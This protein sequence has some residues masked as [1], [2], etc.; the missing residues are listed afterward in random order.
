MSTGFASDLLRYGTYPTALLISVVGALVT[1]ERGADPGLV[2]TTISLGWIPLF[3]AIERWCPE[4]T[5]WRPPRSEVGA[6]VL[7]MLVS[8]PI[9]MAI[10]RATLYGAVVAASG[11]ITERFGLELWPITWPLW[12]QAG[13]AILVA[14]LANYAIHRGMHESRLWPLHAVHHCS[15]RMYFLLS[16]RKHPLQSFV[17]YGG[18]FAVL[19][20]LGVGEQALAVYTALIATNSYLQHVNAPL[21]TGPLGLVFATPE[22]HRIHHSNRPEEIDANYG[23]SLILWDRLFG[24]YR[25]PDP[26][27]SVH[28]AIGLPGI[29][30]PQTFGEHLRL[31]FVWHRLVRGEGGTPAVRPSDGA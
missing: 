8:N 15:P 24:T 19:W 7:H 26:D 21:V 31:P 17:T 5:S 10:L 4:T 12:A 16:M 25:E 11:A 23:D 13:L 28:D 29:E 27:R 30:V 1:I 22:L 9:P 14:E 3:V 20:L 2:V 18:R 6:D